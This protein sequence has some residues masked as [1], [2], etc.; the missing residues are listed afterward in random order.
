MAEK[1]RRPGQKKSWCVVKKERS[2]ATFG[3]FIPADF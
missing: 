1:K 2:G 3:P